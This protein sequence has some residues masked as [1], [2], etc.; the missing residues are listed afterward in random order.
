MTQVTDAIKVLNSY[1][2]TET[3]PPWAHISTVHFC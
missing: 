1:K 3:M 2:C